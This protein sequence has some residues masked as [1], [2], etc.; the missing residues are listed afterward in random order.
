MS[1]RTLL[2]PL[3]V[4][5][6]AAVI[7][8]AIASGGGGFVGPGLSAWPIVGGLAMLVIVTLATQVK[9]VAEVEPTEHGARF[10]TIT[11]QTA[12][13]A[14]GL[15]VVGLALLMG[16]CAPDLGART[17]GLPFAAW[18]GFATLSMGI[19][20]AIARSAL[21]RPRH[22]ALVVPA[23]VLSLDGEP[24]LGSRDARSEP[25]PGN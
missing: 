14:V 25:R 18:A 11:G 8:G 6:G 10:A 19:V 21:G 15:M 24:A 20:L 1:T 3:A 5:V 13:V 2:L 9:A 17:G 12:V 4:L 23:D 7:D 16:S 22:V